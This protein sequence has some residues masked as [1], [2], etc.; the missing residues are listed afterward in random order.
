MS[1]LKGCTRVSKEAQLIPGEEE[2]GTQTTGG[3][4]LSVMETKT[5]QTGSVNCTFIP[6]QAHHL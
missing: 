1:C 6:L 3:M 2:K 5:L 4:M